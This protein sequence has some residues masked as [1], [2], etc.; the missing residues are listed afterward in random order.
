V[1][2]HSGSNGG[3]ASLAVLRPAR[4]VAFLVTANG[5]DGN[6][7]TSQAL[8]GLYGRLITFH[9]TGR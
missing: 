3:N 4:N 6:G 8:N 5:Y 7:W 1:L 2:D 9:N